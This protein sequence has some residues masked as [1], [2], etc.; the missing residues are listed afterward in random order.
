[1]PS[2][3]AANIL[4]IG[5]ASSGKTTLLNALASFIPADQRI[6]ALEDTP[7]MTLAQPH[8]MYLRARARDSG[9]LP[10]VT[11]RE[12]LANTLRMRPDRIIVGEVRGPEAFDMLQAMNVGHDGVMCTLHAN[13]TREGLQ[14]LENLVLAAGSWT[15][16]CGPY[17]R[18]SPWPSIS[19]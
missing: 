12:L 10:D 15:C 8:V 16:P 6:I 3:S 18:A 11:L 14:R 7:E 5:G 19:S 4:I 9:G 2:R 1:M 17:A 13:S